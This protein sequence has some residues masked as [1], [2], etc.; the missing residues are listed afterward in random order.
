MVELP[1]LIVTADSSSLGRPTPRQ[2]EIDVGAGLAPG[3]RSQVSF[4]NGQEVPYGTKKS[5]RPDW[6][7]GNVCSIEVKNYNI[8]KNQRGLIDNISAQALQRVKE[9]PAGMQQKIVIDIRG[10]NVTN[11]EKNSIIKSIVQK[12]NGIIGPTNIDFKDK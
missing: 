9:L 6:C 10:Q 11:A 2:S 8:A 4:K 7:I 5:V 1:E 3:A 12:T